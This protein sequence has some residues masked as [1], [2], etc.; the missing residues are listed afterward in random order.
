MAD[1]VEKMEDRLMKKFREYSA[2]T[3]I[4][5]SFKCFVAGHAAGVAESREEIR[6][7]NEEFT[8][9][10][11]AMNKAKDKLA[12][13]VEA[14]KKIEDLQPLNER[15]RRTIA[16]EAIQAAGD[17]CDHPTIYSATCARCAELAKGGSGKDE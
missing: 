13:A 6:M 15:E 17:G 9:C 12:A 10:F 7:L 8:R 2:S 14:L 3:D 5:P 16:R 1:K 11:N 4:R